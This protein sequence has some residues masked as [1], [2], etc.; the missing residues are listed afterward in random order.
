MD[1]HPGKHIHGFPLPILLPMTYPKEA[2]PRVI[3][4]QQNQTK[5]NLLMLMGLVLS[6]PRTFQPGS[7]DRSGLGGEGE[8]NEAKLFSVFK[9]QSSARCRWPGLAQL[10]C[11]GDAV[12]RRSTL[13]AA[14]TERLRASSPPPSD[15]H[16][17]FPGLHY[18]LERRPRSPG[19]EGLRFPPCLFSLPCVLLPGEE[20]SQAGQGKQ[21][22]MVAV[23]PGGWESGS[24]K[25]RGSG[26]AQHLL[27]F[28]RRSR[29]PDFTGTTRVLNT[30]ARAEGICWIVA[31]HRCRTALGTANASSWRGSRLPRVP[32]ASARPA[33][34]GGGRSP[35]FIK[36][37][38]QPSPEPDP[39]WL[40]CLL[41]A[42]ACSSRSLFS[43]GHGNT[44][45]CQH[46][47]THT[48]AL[49]VLDGTA[50]LLHR[51]GNTTRRWEPGQRARS[52]PSR[53]GE[54]AAQPVC[55]AGASAAAAVSVR[56]CS[57]RSG[58]CRP[59]L[60]PRM[61]E[62][63]QTSSCLGGSGTTASLGVPHP[64]GLVA[65]ISHRGICGGNWQKWC[66]RR[67]KREDLTFTSLPGE[68]NNSLGS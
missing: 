5:N 38:V 54:D 8:A 14:G 66:S 7:R 33:V 41:P 19:H 2:E 30:A 13:S 63:L 24:L 31:S 36:E 45:A 61:G 35:R 12:W 34:R 40:R 6:L 29:P 39:T 47:P 50:P 58:T 23:W 11:R 32:R 20:R 15:M 42:H 28:R 64:P 9:C 25:C 4:Q 1:G 44:H 55:R 21:G 46:R 26:A 60:C 10:L 3:Q 49:S 56:L 68:S 53:Q 67:G 43:A 18:F 65:S 57:R 16:F 22:C 62:S 37:G 51:V 59:G 17:P 48:P 27:T 52:S